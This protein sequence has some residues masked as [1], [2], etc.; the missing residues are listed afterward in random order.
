MCFRITR[1]ACQ[2]LDKILRFMCPAGKWRQK[3]E[4]PTIGA[5]G[6]LLV[7]R[8][9]CLWEPGREIMTIVLCLDRPQRWPDPCGKNLCLGH[10][11]LFPNVSRMKPLIPRIYLNQKNRYCAENGWVEKV[12]ISTV[13]LENSR[14]NIRHVKQ[15]LNIL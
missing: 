11:K 14:P 4:Q 12:F 13:F 2:S 1:R 10:Y 6:G 8:H 9:R 7:I 3:Q 5:T 15:R